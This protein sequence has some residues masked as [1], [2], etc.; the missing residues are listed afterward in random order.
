MPVERKKT[1]SCNFGNEQGEMRSG[2][3]PGR[4]ARL[5]ASFCVSRRLPRQTSLVSHS[6]PSL[7]VP[8]RWKDGFLTHPLLTYTQNCYK[9]TQVPK[10]CSKTLACTGKIIPAQSVSLKIFIWAILITPRKGSEDETTNLK[11]APFHLLLSPFIPAPRLRFD[12]S[13]VIGNSTPLSGF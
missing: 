1:F 8:Q 9:V 4:L 2:P 6:C 13:L 5:V 12:A 7:R 10:I 3:G 11:H